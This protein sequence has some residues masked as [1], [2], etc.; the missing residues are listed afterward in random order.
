M[1]SDPARSTRLNLPTLRRSSPVA[2]DSLMWTVIEK[3]EC[4]RLVGGEQVRTFPLGLK[5]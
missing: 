3:M 2:D 4:E 5:H 1:F